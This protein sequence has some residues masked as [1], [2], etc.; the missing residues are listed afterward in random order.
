MV[1]NFNLIESLFY[2]NEGNDMFMHLQVIRR[3]KDHP[4][5]PCA[6]KTIQT[7][8]VQS[9]EHL[10]KI[11]DEV[12]QLCEMHGARAYINVAGKDFEK[13]AKLANFKLS[14]RIYNGDFKKIYKIFNSAAGE[15]KSRT[16][17]WIIDIDDISYKEEVL[18]WLDVYFE[19][20]L[21]NGFHSKTM[22]MFYLKA[23][24]P[25]KNGVHLI[26]ERPFNLQQFKQ[27]FPF[28]DVH[29]NNP[30]ILYIPKSLD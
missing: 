4:D 23:E 30:T 15:L 10:E 17:R 21:D 5:L 22:R 25:T 19:E 20:E 11:K 18:K 12:I 28:V 6:N 1:N 13:L 9:K 8:Y 29:K 2:F 27:I 14:E 26:I 16:T 7:Y 3:G 24:I